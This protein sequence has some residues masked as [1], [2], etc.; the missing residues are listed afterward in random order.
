MPKIFSNVERERIVENLQIAASTALSQYGV[1]KTTVDDLCSSCHIAK[2]S[3]YLFFESKED[4]FLSLIDVFIE[5][6][7]KLYLDMLQNLDENHI[8]TSLTEVFFSIAKLF[9]HD[10]MFRFFD[11]ENIALIKRKVSTK[12]LESVKEDEKKA[13]LELFSYFSI[14]NEEDIKAFIR[15]YKAILRLYLFNDD[16]LE[17]EKTIK[18]LIRGLVLQMVE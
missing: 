9:Y 13:F 7:Q 10:G 5:K 14:D 4:L 6:V 18:F 15:G 3:F 8:V 16:I 2:G 11:S 12:R 17:T 1:K